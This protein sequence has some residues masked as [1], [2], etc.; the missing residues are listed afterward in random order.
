MVSCERL[1]G[2][3][4]LGP[5]QF[6]GPGL[7]GVGDADEGQAPLRGGGAPPGGERL[8]GHAQGPV[9]VGRPRDRGLGEGVAGAGVDQ[10][11]VGPVLGVAVGAPDEVLQRAHACSFPGSA[12]LLQNHR[13]SRVPTSDFRDIGTRNDEF[14]LTEV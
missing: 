13:R 4:A 12:G 11:A 1:A 3:L 9:D 8:G 5:D 10:G 2:V 7:D 14:C 6:L